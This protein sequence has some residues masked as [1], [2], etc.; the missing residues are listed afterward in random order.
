MS[1]VKP[2]P[3]VRST[4]GKQQAHE[5]PGGR[6][7]EELPDGLV[8][9]VPNRLRNNVQHLQPVVR[10][11]K[12]VCSFPVESADHNARIELVQKR[13]QLLQ[14]SAIPLLT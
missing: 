12:Y 4:F 6:T 14:V 7:D 2:K 9:N 1:K 13:L 3:P 10:I 8:T 5:D 11:A